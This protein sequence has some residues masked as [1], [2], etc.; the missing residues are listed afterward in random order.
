MEKIQITTP[1]IKKALRRYKIPRAISQY[2][3]NGFDAQAS[4]VK[5]VID[6]NEIGY[7]N[8]YNDPQKLDHR[9]R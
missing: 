1:G 7:I 6:A 2:I 9:L 8:E 3:W 4:N 5:V